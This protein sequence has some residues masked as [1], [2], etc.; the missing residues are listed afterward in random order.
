MAA[1]VSLN[2][3]DGVVAIEETN[4]LIGAGCT[5]GIAQRVSR[6]LRVGRGRCENRGR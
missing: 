2:I 6:Q 3:A 4:R 5:R 1:G